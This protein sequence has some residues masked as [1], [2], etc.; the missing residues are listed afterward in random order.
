M[1]AYTATEDTMHDSYYSHNIY[2][3]FQEKKKTS[4]HTLS[5]GFK[6]SRIQSLRDSRTQGLKHSRTQGFRHSKTQGLTDGKTPRFMLGHLFQEQPHQTSRAQ[7]SDPPRQSKRR[8][9]SV[10]RFCRRSQSEKKRKPKNEKSIF[11][12]SCRNRY[13]RVQKPEKSIR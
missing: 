6:E 12:H 2:S 11:H 4:C 5:Q 1:C 8:H 9:L 13:R 3:Y 7:S 10:R